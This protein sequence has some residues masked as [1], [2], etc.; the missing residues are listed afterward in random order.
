[1]KD[2]HDIRFHTPGHGWCPDWPYM[3]TMTIEEVVPTDSAINRFLLVMDWCVERFGE[4]E[5]RDFIVS[6]RRKTDE[7]LPRWFFMDRSFIVLF[8]DAQDAMEFKL[9]W[10]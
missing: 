8:R 3:Y 2:F 4:L 5:D 10:L 1:M 7:S 6:M 9:K